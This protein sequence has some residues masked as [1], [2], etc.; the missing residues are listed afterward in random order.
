MN[1]VAYYPYIVQ[2]KFHPTEKPSVFPQR[3][4]ALNLTDSY[5]CCYQ[6][7]PTPTE[8]VDTALSPAITGSGCSYCVAVYSCK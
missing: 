8:G 5:S 4:M 1:L 3:T 6:Q 2:Y 7:T